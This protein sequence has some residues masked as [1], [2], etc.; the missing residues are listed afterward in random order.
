[1]GRVN[2]WMGAVG[3]AAVLACA[4]AGCDA[5]TPSASPGATPARS[6][7]AAGGNGVIAAA[8]PASSANASPANASPVLPDGRSPAY[9]TGLDT[10]AG[11]VTFDLIEFL[12]GDAA[13][14]EWKKEHPQDPNGPDDD[15]MIINNNKK[16]RTLPVAPDAQCLVLTS[17]GSTGTT[18][19]GFADL[20][21]YLTQQG[22]EVA[23][24]APD[25]AVLPF[26]LTV[27]H[28]TVVKFEEQFLP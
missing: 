15:Y 21:A 16:L 19:I 13:K 22:K 24:K 10:S 4:L 6:G 23:P 17:L 26:W 3:G 25:I 8:S 1:M 27:Q 9:L 5:K 14:A 7:S 2:R 11:T 20:P 18:T 28:G 12:T